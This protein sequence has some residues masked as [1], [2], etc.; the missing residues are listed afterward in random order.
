MLFS[1]NNTNGD[2]IMTREDQDDF[3]KSNFCRSREKKFSDKVGGHCH[4]TGKN[5]GPDHSKCNVIVTQKRSNF[6]PFAFHN[7]INRDFHLL[8]KVSWE[9]MRN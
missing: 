8:Q 5:R 6:I 4:L 2:K 9:K 3:D 7:F 1:L